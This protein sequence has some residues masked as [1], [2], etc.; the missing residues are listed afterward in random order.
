[1]RRETNNQKELKQVELIEK[2][3]M[4]EIENTLGGLTSKLDTV[5]GK[6]NEIEDIAIDTTQTKAQREKKSANKINRAS[7]ICVKISS[8]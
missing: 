4:H 6:M 2:N 7:I 5:K 3:I 1:M 8:T